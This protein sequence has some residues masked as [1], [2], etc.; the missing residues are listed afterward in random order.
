MRCEVLLWMI[1]TIFTARYQLLDLS[2]S[3]LRQ[4]DDVSIVGM[5]LDT[6]SAAPNNP[7]T[8]IR[9]VA[10][11]NRQR[12]TKTTFKGEQ[13]VGHTQLPCTLFETYSMILGIQMLTTVAKGSRPVPSSGPRALRRRDLNTA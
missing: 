6:P 13:D 1:P 10:I 3:F 4:L 7:R 11:S 5:R 12:C 2:D 9:T 8:R